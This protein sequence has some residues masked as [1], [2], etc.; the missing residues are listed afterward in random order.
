[1][2]RLSPG[3]KQMICARLQ[4]QSSEELE[5]T[6]LRYAHHL[7]TDHSE[8]LESSEQ[9]YE[10]ACIEQARRMSEQ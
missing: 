8:M 4:T 7:R 1:M 10:L 6:I 3:L 9:I 5:E 2:T